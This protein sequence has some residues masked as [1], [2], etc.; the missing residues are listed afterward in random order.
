MQR[1]THVSLYGVYHSDDCVAI[2]IDIEDC[3][4]VEFP[5]TE[6][7]DIATLSIVDNYLEALNEYVTQILED[8]TWLDKQSKLCLLRAPFCIYQRK[9]D[10]ILFTLRQPALQRLINWTLRC[11]NGIHCP[12]EVPVF[13][14]LRDPKIHVPRKTRFPAALALSGSVHSGLCYIGRSTSP[15][16]SFVANIEKHGLNFADGV[17]AMGYSESANAR[18]VDVESQTVGHIPYVVK[19]DTDD[20]VQH[21]IAIMLDFDAQSTDCNDPNDDGLDIDD[22]ADVYVVVR[23]GTENDTT[24]TIVTDVYGAS[25]I[26]LGAAVHREVNTYFLHTE[27]REMPPNGETAH[28]KYQIAMAE[29]PLLLHHETFA[30]ADQQHGVSIP[31]ELMRYH[32]IDRGRCICPSFWIVLVFLGSV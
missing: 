7:F 22:L 10:G 17:V 31:S 27:D 30:I 12:I 6:L 28:T 26:M 14:R 25:L 2:T 19:R 8:T 1:K 21:T 20:H 13:I 18:A 5:L 16:R 4:V 3:P 15:N 23:N 11:R 9:N 29:M 32:P 24:V